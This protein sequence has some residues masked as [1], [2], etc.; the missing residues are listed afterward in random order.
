MT[1]FPGREGVFPSLVL[2]TWQ[3]VQ[4][5]TEKGRPSQG[6]HTFGPADLFTHT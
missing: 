2:V 4:Q 1:S 6:L 3:P 5:D